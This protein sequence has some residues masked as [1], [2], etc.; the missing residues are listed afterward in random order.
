MKNI[1]ETMRSYSENRRMKNII[2]KLLLYYGNLCNDNSTFNLDIVKDCYSNFQ[3]ISKDLNNIDKN[4][5]ETKLLVTGEVNVNE[6]FK[7]TNMNI[8]S[9]SCNRIRDMIINL[10][11]ELSKSKDLY[12]DAVSFICIIGALCKMYLDNVSKTKSNVDFKT[13]DNKYQ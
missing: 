5:T 1:I 9:F 3:K 13:L 2:D 10:L 8:N 11:D 7:E 6:V 4:I 12:A